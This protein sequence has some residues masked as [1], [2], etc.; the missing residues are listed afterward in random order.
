MGKGGT[1]KKKK[2]KVTYIDDGSTVADMSSLGGGKRTMHLGD[3]GG[4]KAR[5][6]T[7]V[8]AVRR[9]MMPML[10]TMG[11]ICVVFLIIYLLLELAS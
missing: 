8:Q 5:W 11:G 9:M 7:Y 2:E 4:F 6:Q 1:K 10:V 3:T